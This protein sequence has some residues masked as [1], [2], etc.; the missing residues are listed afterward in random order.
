MAAFS[1]KLWNHKNGNELWCVY[2]EVTNFVRSERTMAAEA[3]W[4]IYVTEDVCASEAE[5]HKIAA[6]HKNGRM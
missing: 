2:S 6:D 5:L 4:F 1:V 3:S